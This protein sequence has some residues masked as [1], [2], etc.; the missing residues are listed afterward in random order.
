MQLNCKPRTQPTSNASRHHSFREV[1]GVGNCDY[2]EPAIGH[3]GP[4]EEVINDVLLG[5]KE[6]IKFVH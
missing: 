5:G 6:L 3:C 1:H 2:D 4:I